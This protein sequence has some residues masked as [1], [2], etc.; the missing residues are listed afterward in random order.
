MIIDLKDLETL[1]DCL[2]TGA[3]FMTANCRTLAASVGF[4]S[5]AYLIG[6]NPPRL[7]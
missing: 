2:I 1:D 7:N 6:E 4:S 3:I 5:L